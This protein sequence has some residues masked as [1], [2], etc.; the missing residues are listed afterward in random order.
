[1][2]AGVF[3]GGAEALGIVGPKATSFISCAE[4][5]VSGDAAW[6]VPGIPAGFKSVAAGEALETF[7]ST[8]AER[9]YTAKHAT[10]VTITK[11]A[12]QNFRPGLSPLS[13][14]VVDV[15]ERF[16]ILNLCTFAAHRCG[17]QGCV[18]GL[19]AILAA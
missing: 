2:P 13:V 11:P 18:A 19:P 12:I 10:A 16:L 5:L 6:L 4:A 3:V 7:D 15:A 14:L 8:G 17:V 9:S 1:M